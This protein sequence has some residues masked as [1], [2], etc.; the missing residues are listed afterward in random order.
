M[1]YRHRNSE[2]KSRTLQKGG[3]EC[4]RKGNVWIELDFNFYSWHQ[5]I[6]GLFHS[7]IKT[8]FVH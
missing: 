2:H 4:D 6:F 8:P 1:G 3:F 7:L 5:S